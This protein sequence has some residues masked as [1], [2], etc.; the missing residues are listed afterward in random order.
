MTFLLPHKPSGQDGMFTALL[1]KFAQMVPAS[2]RVLPPSPTS[3]PHK[4]AFHDSG[5]KLHVFCSSSSRSLTLFDAHVCPLHEDCLNADLVAS[6]DLSNSCLIVSQTLE[7]HCC[8]AQSW[9]EQTYPRE[10]TL[11]ELFSRSQPKLT[12]H[13][14]GAKSMDDL[15][16]FH[17]LHQ[18]GSVAPTV[19]PFG[20]PPLLLFICTC[21]CRTLTAERSL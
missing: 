11:Y 5:I 9:T 13:V 14:C 15:T 20:S 8:D 16:S 1:L 6:S 12:I 19:S 21:G 4:K 18:I 3:G 10:T 7:Y 17:C 2:M